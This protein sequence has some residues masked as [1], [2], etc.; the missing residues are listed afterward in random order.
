MTAFLASGFGYDPDPENFRR[1]Y[2]GGSDAGPLP[3]EVPNSRFQKTRR[4][5]YL[6][7]IGEIT[8][9]DLFS[10]IIMVIPLILLFEI[11]ILIAKFMKRGVAEEVAL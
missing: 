5:V 11:T 10:L 9:P 2:V 3:G 8:P 4:E 6:Q 7:K 1:T